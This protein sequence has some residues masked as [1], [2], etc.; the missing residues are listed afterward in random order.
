[1]AK[2]VSEWD[3]AYILSLPKESDEFERKGSKLLDLTV[4]GV[5]S[6]KVAD[7]LAKQLSAFANSGG[8]KIIYGLKDDGA[9][10]LGGVSTK[11]KDCGTKDWLEQRIPALTEYEIIGFS[12]HEFGPIASSSQIDPGKALY[13]VDVPDSDRAPHQSRRDH[14]YYVRLGSQSSP[15][16][17]KM[18]EDIRNR[19]KHPRVSLK[20]RSELQ[21]TPVNNEPD[22]SIYNIETVLF[23]SLVNEGTLKSA[24]TFILLE[25]EGGICYDDH[26]DIIAV[27]VIGTK[28]GSCQWQL[29]RPLPPQSKIILRVS[30]RLRAKRKLVGHTTV[31]FEW[32]DITER[33]SL[34]DMAINWTI[35]ADSAPP[36]KGRVTMKDIGL[37][38]SLSSL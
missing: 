22:R 1:M 10:D 32:F 30:C 16:P 4:T 2:P 29:A 26:N 38:Q 33:M 20:V 19:Q 6:D 25:P 5:T 35:F 11:I 37:M 27:G 17:H 24:D 36:H 15:A 28:K 31:R 12:V 18:I 9:V 21:S 34:E 13:V 23:L 3:E 7:E 8:G 14:K